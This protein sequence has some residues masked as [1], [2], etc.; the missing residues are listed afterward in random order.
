MKRV[1]RNTWYSILIYILLYYSIVWY[2]SICYLYY[3]PTSVPYHIGALS[4]QFTT[5]WQRENRYN[6]I[7]FQTPDNQLS[8]MI[9]Y[10]SDLQKRIGTVQYYIGKFEVKHH[11]KAYLGLHRY[12]HESGIQ[13]VITHQEGILNNTEDRWIHIIGSI[14]GMYIIRIYGYVEAYDIWKDDI[15]YILNNIVI[16]KEELL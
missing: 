12:I 5:R 3:V 14:E 1:E 7:I 16:E 2:I 9:L 6:T 8:F 15:D 11:D 4:G 10:E 13:L